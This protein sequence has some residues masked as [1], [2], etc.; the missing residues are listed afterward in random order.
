MNTQ[1]RNISY[2]QHKIIAWYKINRRNFIWRGERL[3]DYQKIITEVL[4]QRTKAETVE[5]FYPVFI[6]KYKTWQD[7]TASSI[8]TLEE[9]L[10]PIG[11]Y[12][13]RA[14]RLY[15]LSLE[16]CKLAGKIPGTE[17]E[18]SK[19]PMI[20]Q[21]IANAILLIIHDKRRPLLDTN[22]ARVLER[23]FG[24][25]KLS[26]IRYDPYLQ[27]L[28]GKVVDHEMAKEINWGILD[29]ASAICKS[30]N[31]LCFQCLVNNRCVAFNISTEDY[32]P[33]KP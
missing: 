3:N 20:G 9:D 13:Q 21:Y 17:D 22:M 26:D 1:R 23:F 28:A 14:K 19:I 18:L 33:P 25:R 4:L 5:K 6:D 29:F 32:H 15:S 10:K 31:P 24:K 16:M 27:N 12:R 8:E 2:F 7:I 11:L 30:R